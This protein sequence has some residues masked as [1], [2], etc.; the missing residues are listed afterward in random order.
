MHGL[1][2]KFRLSEKMQNIPKLC[3]TFQAKHRVYIKKTI[4]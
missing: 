1:W 2:E 4:K 3:I